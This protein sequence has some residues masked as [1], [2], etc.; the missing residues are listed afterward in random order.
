MTMTRMQRRATGL[1]MLMLLSGCAALK[2]KGGPK[3]P[4]VGQRVPILTSENAIEADPSIGVDADVAKAKPTLLGY[5]GGY[6]QWDNNWK[7][8][9]RVGVQSFGGVDRRRDDRTFTVQRSS[10]LGDHD[11]GEA[12]TVAVTAHDRI[13]DRLPGERDLGDEDHVRPPGQAPF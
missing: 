10:A 12:S 8:T 9:G 4:V 11:D 3:T 6:Y 7:F 1:A 5:V 2:S 13:G